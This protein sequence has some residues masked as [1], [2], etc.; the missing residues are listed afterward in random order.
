VDARDEQNASLRERLDA[1]ALEL[2]R[3]AGEARASEW[4][5]TE[6]ER[7]IAL[8]LPPAEPS[9]GAQ[10]RLSALLDEVEVLRQALVQEHEARVRAESAIAP[11][12]PEHDRGT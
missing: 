9:D 3:S 6:L 8:G 12:A 7:R 10:S 2:A 1:L 5:I 11:G 4:K